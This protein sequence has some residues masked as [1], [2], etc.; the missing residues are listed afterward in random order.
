MAE[1]TQGLPGAVTEP[2]KSSAPL[3]PVTPTSKL[4]GMALEFALLPRNLV[5]CPNMKLRHLFTASL[6][7]P[8]A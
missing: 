8:Q 3:Q 4:A 1:G 2:R 5:R 7:G 6:E